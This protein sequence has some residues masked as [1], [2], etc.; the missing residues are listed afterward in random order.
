MQQQMKADN[1]MWWAIGV[2]AIIAVLLFFLMTRVGDQPAPAG[3]PVDTTGAAA[4][5]TGMQQHHMDTQPQDESQEHMHGDQQHM[6][7]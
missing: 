3:V 1:V 7:E 4:G 6:H 2:V 5:T